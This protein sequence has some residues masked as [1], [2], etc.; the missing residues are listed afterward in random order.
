MTDEASN[1]IGSASAAAERPLEDVTVLDLTTALAGPYCT[2]VLAGL[3]ARVIK[4]ENPR[5]GETARGNAPYLGADGLTLS[6]RDADDIS[7]ALL[8]RNRDKLGVTLD[9]KRPEGKQ[10]LHDLVRAS[11]VLV[12]NFSP[13]A[14]RKL[15]ADYDSLEAVNPALVYC[16]ISGFGA[17][18][19]PERAKAMDT[20]IQAASGLMM[21][22]GEEGDAPTRV[23]IPVADAVAPLYAVIGILASLRRAEATGQGEFVDVSMLGSVSAL[24]ALEHWAAL[25]Q[26]EQPTRTGNVLPRLTPFGIFGTSD[27]GYVA[28]CAPTDVFAAALLSAAGVDDPR[29][30][31]RFDTR[32]HRVA[33]ADEVNG[34]V[35]A[36]TRRCTVDEVLAELEPRGVPV[37]PVRTPSEAVRDPLLLARGETLPLEH[38]RHGHVADVYGT[39]LPITGSKREFG[40]REPAPD[41]GQ[42]SDRIYRELGYSEERLTELRRDGII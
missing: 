36:W 39:G 31:P 8:D 1:R 34:V 2:L 30:D 18:S 12:T 40:F 3:G 29:T 28:I 5:G 21:T 13:A 33:H 37:T 7:L 4:V 27:G 38:P 26:L 41:L 19:P 14:V 24:V 32:D 20:I 42:H 22:C 17:D 15:E 9:L 23:G 10:V 6:R 35:E 16:A 11:D 25:E